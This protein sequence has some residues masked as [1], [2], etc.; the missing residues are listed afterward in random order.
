MFEVKPETLD[1]ETSPSLLSNNLSV[2]KEIMV[3]AHLE[4]VVV[5]NPKASKLCNKIT[6]VEKAMVYQVLV[7]NLGGET[8]LVIATESGCQIW[9]ILGEHLHYSLSLAKELTGDT[10]LQAH[11]CRGIA[12]DDKSVFVGSSASKLF[13]LTLEPGQCKGQSEFALHTTSTIGVHSEPLHALSTP[14]D[15]TRASVLV[16]SDDDGVIAVWSLDSSGAP[17]IKHKLKPTG[18]PVTCIQAINSTWAVAGD[19]TGKLRLVQLQD[20]YIAA[21]V[22]AHTRNLS[23]LAIQDSHVASV[24][25]DGY[26]HLW[27]L[28]ERGDRLKISLTHSFRVGDDLLTGVAFSAQNLVTASYDLNHVKVWK[29]KA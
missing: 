7:C 14:P 15:E 10:E 24:G 11:Y 3:F 22:G 12:H 6:L 19:V 28:T 17:E 16:S 1:A 2:S 26:L 23:A 8:H 21:D 13:S 4:D 20:G 5:L 25:E 27:K 18:Y 29:A 9:D